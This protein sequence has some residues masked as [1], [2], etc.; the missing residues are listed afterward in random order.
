MCV[1]EEFI[2]R[3]ESSALGLIQKENKFKY[4]HVPVPTQRH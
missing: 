4:N 2:G 1:I 3:Q